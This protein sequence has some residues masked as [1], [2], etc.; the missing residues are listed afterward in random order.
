[1]WLFVMWSMLLLV[2]KLLSPQMLT[3][4]GLRLT[5]RQVH[6]DEGW[7]RFACCLP[8]HGRCEGASQS[9]NEE[10]KRATT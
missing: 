1:M 4:K 10:E 3:R 8:V 9:Q 6:T 7:V 2:V 5:F